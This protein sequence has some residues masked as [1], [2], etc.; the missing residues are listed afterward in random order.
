[1][2]QDQEAAAQHTQTL[3][4][5]GVTLLNF[6]R[7]GAE[8]G[9]HVARCLDLLALPRK[10]KVVD[11]GSGTGAFARLA[12]EIRPDIQFTL[13]ND[14]AWQLEQSR[15]S[16]AR[17]CADMADTGLPSG[18]FDAVILAYALGH[19]AAANVL[20]EAHRLLRVGGKMLL[21]DAHAQNIGVFNR[22]YEN[23]H[24]CAYNLTLVQFWA[25]VIGFDH[26]SFTPDSFLAPGDVVREYYASG[27][28]E[29]LTHGVTVFHKTDRPHKTKGRNVGLQF[30]GGKDSM[31]CLFMLE[32]FLDHIT[33]Y[34]LNTGDTIPE[35]REVID[36][37]RPAIPHFVEVL[38]DVKTWRDTYGTPSDLV[39]TSAH[40][41]GLMYGMAPIRISNKFD[42][43]LQ[44]LMLPMHR[45]AMDDGVDLLIR[46]T[47]L[48]DT[49]KIPFEGFDENGVEVWLP[50]RDLTHDEVLALLDIV[51]APVNP[52]YEHFTGISAPECLGCTAWWDDNKGQYLKASHPEQHAEYITHL[53]GIKQAMQTHIEQLDAELSSAGDTPWE[54]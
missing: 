27:N 25:E 10:A 21:H 47:K 22:H 46:G 43:C 29:G 35:T 51:G 26:D 37:L 7:L 12:G 16:A 18:D 11:L 1:M 38:S 5:Q 6:W 28:L 2:Y 52:V 48:F 33:V 41:I 8:E 42:C 15:S 44:N 45:R 50:V 4:K 19:G 30:S 36:S 49:G 39:P 40:N 17:V 54:E 23:L 34:H 14:H 20:E 32:P 31:A 13:V 3:E 53:R 24:Y 9:A